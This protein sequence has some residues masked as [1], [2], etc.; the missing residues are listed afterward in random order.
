VVNWLQSR[1][2]LDKPVFSYGDDVYSANDLITE[3]KKESNV[4][5]AHIEMMVKEFESSLEVNE[6]DSQQYDDLDDATA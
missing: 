2:E 1:G 3:V 6:D 5:L 4:G